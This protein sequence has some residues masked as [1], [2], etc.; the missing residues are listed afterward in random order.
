MGGVYTEHMAER[1]E[2]NREK[3]EEWGS[4][5]RDCDNKWGVYIYSREESTRV[6]RRWGGRNVLIENNME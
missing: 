5:R 3:E 4:R 2:G 6:G 1:K